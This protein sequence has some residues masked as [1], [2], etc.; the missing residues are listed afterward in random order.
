MRESLDRLGASMVVQ[1]T[2]VRQLID[3]GQLVIGDGY[4]AKNDEL[5]HT[6][7]P[8]ARA[9]NIDAGFSFDGADCYPLEHLARVGNKV[10][11]PGDVVFTSKGTVG[12]FAFVRDNT[13]SFVYSPQLCF[14]RSLDVDYLHP[15][16]LFY[17]MQSHDFYEQFKGVA[18]QT[19]MAEYVSL[20]DQRSMHIS[21]PPLEEQRA[22]ARVLG[23]LDARIELNRRTSETL[24][25]MART[26]F[27]SWF[28]DFDPVQAKADGEPVN[29]ICERLRLTPELLAL[30]PD[31]L[32]DSPLGPLP[33]GW[34]FAP[35]VELTTYLS[36]GISPKYLEEG[37]VL[38][39]NQRC[40]RDGK[41]DVAKGRRHDVRA[42][43]IAGRNLRGG[44]VLV[45][46]TG[47]GT[48]GRVA[49]V[50]AVDEATVVDSHVT[51][52]RAD[53]RIVASLYLGMALFERQADIEALAEGS[54]GQTELSR[55]RLGALDILI[56]PAPLIAEFVS[57]VAPMR[58]AS[59][60][61]EL[62][63]AAIAAARDALLPRLLSGE[64]R[65]VPLDV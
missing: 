9:Q 24:E 44:D 2:P 53:E 29:S 10:S 30:F 23:A 33:T 57:R 11:R 36:R 64:L 14:W 21:V 46:S 52:V 45:N 13:P 59:Y 63:S 61:N 42:R 35:L 58:V 48:L 55:A 4:R 40:I 50:M 51:V 31:E 19:D 62:Q 16:W 27:Q 34:R 6:G 43:S 25:R 39:L 17:W 3:A 8:F 37:G 38:V 18:G 47:V 20:R 15:E 1:R 65:A 22:T 26:L 49:Q 32:D 54:T 41:V 56:P 12:R 60:A 7:L 28:V 5:T